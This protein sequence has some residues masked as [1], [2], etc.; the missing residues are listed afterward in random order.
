MY[1]NCLKELGQ[2]NVRT[3]VGYFHGKL[4]VLVLKIQKILQIGSINILFQYHKK[5]KKTL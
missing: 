1:A 2:E 4:T 3:A 5:S